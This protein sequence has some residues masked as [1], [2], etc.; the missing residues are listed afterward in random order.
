M[1]VLFFLV[2]AVLASPVTAQQTF[3]DQ[4][5]FAACSKRTN[6]LSNVNAQ[7]KQL[8]LQADQYNQQHDVLRVQLDRQEAEVH[9]IHNDLRGKPIKR[10]NWDAYDR[11]F[12]LYEDAFIALRDWNEAGETLGVKIDQL[13]K[14]VKLL[15]GEI[16]AECSGNWEPAIINK[17]CDD[18]SGR[19]DAF[20]TAFEK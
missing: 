10:N 16:N 15:Q 20:C 8:H 17:F 2:I 12:Q 13:T 6:Q 14:T 9:R 18:N 19:H 5:L 1:R 11:A 7:L 3:V 4:E